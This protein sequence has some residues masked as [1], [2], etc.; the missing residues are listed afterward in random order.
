MAE[1]LKQVWKWL[2]H[3]DA[4][5]DALAKRWDKCMINVGV[6]YVKK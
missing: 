6:G 3:C 5:F 4:G 2:R 1:R